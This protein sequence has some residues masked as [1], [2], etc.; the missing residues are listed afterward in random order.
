MTDAQLQ[1]ELNAYLGAHGL[2]R[3]LGTMYFVYFPTGVNHV[4]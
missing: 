3:G 4:L 1:S 2:P